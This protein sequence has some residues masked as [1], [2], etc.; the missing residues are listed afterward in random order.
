[1]TESISL[2][3]RTSNGAE[4]LRQ[5]R[6]TPVQ[7]LGGRT[8][9]QTCLQHHTHSLHHSISAAEGDSQSVLRGCLCVRDG[10]D[11]VHQPRGEK[12]QRSAARYSDLSAV[13]R[14]VRLHRPIIPALLKLSALAWIHAIISSG[15]ILP[16][17]RDKQLEAKAKMEARCQSASRFFI[18]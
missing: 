5:V 7:D 15:G 18:Q 13:A 10:P 1:M 8:V 17:T 6:G 3:S 16:L 9:H 11:R 12:P 14:S 2:K 4:V